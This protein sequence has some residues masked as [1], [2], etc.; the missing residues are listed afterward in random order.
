MED[1]LGR[2]IIC[3]TDNNIQS[4]NALYLSEVCF[5]LK[6]S[7][8]NLETDPAHSTTMNIFNS[9]ISK[10]KKSIRLKKKH[11]ERDNNKELQISKEI[12]SLFSISYEKDQHK[13]LA[14][15][16]FDYKNLQISM[17]PCRTCKCVVMI[18][19]GQNPD[20]IVCT[21]CK[22]LD[23]E[24]NID[25]FLKNNLLPLWKNNNKWQFEQPEELIDLTLGEKL[26]IQKYQGKIFLFPF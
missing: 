5:G 16:Q 12:Q 9:R 6:S 10:M 13:I 22:K 25:L 24:T 3:F 14:M 2:K 4:T 19:S 20:T 21:G 11:L 26:C 15:L 1:K 8:N 18:P 7:F 23:K 17:K